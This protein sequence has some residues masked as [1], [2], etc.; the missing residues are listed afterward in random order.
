MHEDDLSLLV[1]T[2]GRKAPRVAFGGERFREDSPCPGCGTYYGDV[3]QWGCEIEEC[4]FCGDSL[5]ACDCLDAP[6]PG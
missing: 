2:D 6:R 1:A 4:P 5:P 3:H